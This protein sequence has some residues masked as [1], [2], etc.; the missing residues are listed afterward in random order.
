MKEIFRRQ[1]PIISFAQILPICY[2]MALLAL[3]AQI[4]VVDG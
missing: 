1:N 2:Y 4:A 3:L